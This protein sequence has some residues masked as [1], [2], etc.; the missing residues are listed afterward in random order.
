MKNVIPQYYIP[1]PY[2]SSNTTFYHG[3]VVPCETLN[4]LIKNKNLNSQSELKN[5]KSHFSF[6]FCLTALINFDSCAGFKEGTSRSSITTLS[7][8]VVRISAITVQLDVRCWGFSFS[9]QQNPKPILSCVLQVKF[10]RNTL[11]CLKW[12]HCRSD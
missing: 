4:N 3:Y 2:D 10:P 1:S 7:K 11:K 12:A 5:I 6:H 9:A 8:C